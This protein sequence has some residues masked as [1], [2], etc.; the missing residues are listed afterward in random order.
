MIA[1]LQYEETFATNYAN[2]I[3]PR[4]N[5]DDADQIWDP[6]DS[7]Q[8]KLELR[9]NYQ[10]AGHERIV[11]YY[12][13]II[14]VNRHVHNRSFSRGTTRRACGAL[15]RRRLIYSGNSDAEVYG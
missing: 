7:G 4:I 3:P 8:L 11:P 14:N 13:Y 5:A 10:R 15:V 1:T 2:E 9:T 6:N 12:Y